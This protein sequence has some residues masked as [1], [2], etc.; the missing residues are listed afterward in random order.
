MKINTLKQLK[1]T[2]LFSAL[3]T[4]LVLPLA[5]NA[6]AH[7]GFAGGPGQGHHLKQKMRMMTKF[8]ELDE[9]QRLEIKTIYT[10]AKEGNAEL[11]ESMRGFKDEMSVLFTAETFDE[12]VF[13]ELQEKYQTNFEQM[14]LTRAKTKHAVIQVFTEQQKE[15]WLTRRA[16]KL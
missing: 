14:G 2:I 8:L 15:K 12:E 10:T 3:C 5:S 11:R 9:E 1:S 4:A 7:D 13:S 16:S 6:L